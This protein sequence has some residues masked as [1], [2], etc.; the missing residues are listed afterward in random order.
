MFRIKD[1][2]G[3]AGIFNNSLLNDYA[4]SMNLQAKTN[5]VVINF[6]DYISTLLKFDLHSFYS[7]DIKLNHEDTYYAYEYLVALC[8]NNPSKD[9]EACKVSFLKLLKLFLLECATFNL[10]LWTTLAFHCVCGMCYPLRVNVS[11]GGKYR[12]DDSGNGRYDGEKHVEFFSA[13]CSPES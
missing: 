6:Y 11:E 3:M 7:T 12:G 13:L 8:E 2:T 5:V 1:A 9:Y 4:Y 10:Q